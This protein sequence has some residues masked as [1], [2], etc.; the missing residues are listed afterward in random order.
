MA[1]PGPTRWMTAGAQT[2]PTT[3]V[4]VRPVTDDLLAGKCSGGDAPVSIENFY[5]TSVDDHLTG[6]N[7]RNVIGGEIATICSLAMAA[8]VP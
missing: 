1:A 5:D 6:D 4:W 2:W 3:R 7:V 8:T